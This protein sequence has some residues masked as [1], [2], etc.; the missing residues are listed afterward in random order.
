MVER[1]FFNRIGGKAGKPCVCWQLGFGFPGSPR[2]ALAAASLRQKTR[3]RAQLAIKSTRR[4]GGSP[5]LEVAG[6]HIHM[7][8]GAGALDSVCTSKACMRK[9]TL[10]LRTHRFTMRMLSPVSVTMFG[11]SS[12]FVMSEILNS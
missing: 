1:L 3:V 5:G 4:P 12:T 8:G 7:R 9:P 6:L 10:P 11:S 2:S